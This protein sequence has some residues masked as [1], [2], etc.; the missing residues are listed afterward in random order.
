MNWKMILL[1]SALSFCATPSRALADDPAPQVQCVDTEQ[2]KCVSA[3]K[4]GQPAPF[5][6]QLLSP[7]LAAEQAVAAASV[8]DRLRIEREYLAEIA[9]TKLKL[10][11]EM[12]V[13]DV[14][15]EKEKN[16]LYERE[17]VELYKQ[18]EEARAEDDDPFYERPWFVASA[19]AVVTALV[20]YA[21]GAALGELIP[22]RTQ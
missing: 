7:R 12:R 13:L 22:E 3:L 20:I 14:E 10:E 8:E 18:L 1:L 21:S 2:K 9:A 11:Q 16:K 15:V 6:G 19:T 17:I 4:K 5:D